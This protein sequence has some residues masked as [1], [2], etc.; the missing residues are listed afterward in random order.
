ML[1]TKFTKDDF[2]AWLSAWSLAFLNERMQFVKSGDVISTCL[3]T[4]A[5]AP[6]GTRAGGNDLNLD[7]TCIKYVDDV[8]LASVSLGPLDRL[9]Q[10]SFNSLI[11]WCRINKLNIKE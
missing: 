7:V 1:Y 6:Q 10:L 11:D 4:N 2:P 9:M 8:A 5:G 3:T